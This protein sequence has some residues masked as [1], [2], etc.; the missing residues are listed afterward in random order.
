MSAPA[1]AD[2]FKE[3]AIHMTLLFDR[4]KALQESDGSGRSFAAE[5]QTPKSLRE[6]RQFLAPRGDPISA[7]VFLSAA[8]FVEGNFV[9]PAPRN[10]PVCAAANVLVSHVKDNTD[11]NLFVQAA[12]SYKQALDEWKAQDLEVSKEVEQSLRENV[13]TLMRKAF[14]DRLHEALKDH[15]TE[16]AMPYLM[17][18]KSKIQS[19]MA[20][21][22]QKEA[23]DRQFDIEMLR[24]MIHHGCNFKAREFN[25]FFAP[26]TAT[27]KSLQSSQRDAQLDEAYGA[28]CAQVSNMGENWHEPFVSS[29][30][31]LTE[32]VAYIYMDIAAL[33]PTK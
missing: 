29:I 10:S 26:L 18:L 9:P 24:D 6:A 31:L 11:A 23:M 4:L 28:V 2:T 19:L 20:T 25:M 12:Q 17:D 22:Q 13:G 27:V 21:Q 7:R 8:A 5:I 30:K 1:S 16:V 33:K 3:T 14:W 32:F 15:N